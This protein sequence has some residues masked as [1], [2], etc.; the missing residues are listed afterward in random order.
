VSARTAAAAAGRGR[1]A[2]PRGRSRQEQVEAARVEDLAEG[3][4]A[5][6][7]PAGSALGIWRRLHTSERRDGGSASCG[8]VGDGYGLD[9]LG[10]EKSTKPWMGILLNCCLKLYN[11]C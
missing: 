4:T 5:E 3:A 6:R 2:R 8:W 7:G 10:L 9:G 1:P 11:S